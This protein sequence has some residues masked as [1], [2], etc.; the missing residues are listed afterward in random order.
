MGALERVIALFQIG[1]ER[2]PFVSLPLGEIL[3]RH[4]E[5]KDLDVEGRLALVERSCDEPPDLV[6]DVV[7]HGEAADRLAAAMYHDEGAGAALRAVE[8]IGKAEAE[9]TVPAAIGIELFLGHGV[10]ALGRLAVAFAE[11]RAKPP[12]PETNRIGGKLLV[13]AVPLH[14]D[15]ELRL[16]LEDAQEYRRAEREPLCL[17][18]L[19][20]LGKLGRAREREPV[21]M[22]PIVLPAR[23]VDG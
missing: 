21:A 20:E 13:T 6:D 19:V 16:E 22:V 2:A 8:R 10:E 11:L 5:G 18:P 14:P 4:A 17:Q 12:R 15:L 3:L 1:P 9:G 23:V 7:G